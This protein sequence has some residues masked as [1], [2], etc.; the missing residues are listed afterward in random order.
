MH[1]LLFVDLDDTLFHSHNKRQPDTHDVALAYLQDGSAISYANQKQMTMLKFWQESHVM[2]P[3]TAR[4][5]NAFERVVIEFKHGAVINYGGIVLQADG[6][7]DEAW[8]QQ[9]QAHARHS[10]PILQVLLDY[11]NSLIQTTEYSSLH[12]RIISDVG[13]A[14]Y[15][16]LKSKTGDLVQVAQ[17]T[18]MV[19]QFL[20][21]EGWTEYQV[22]H[23][24]NNLAIMPPWLNKRHGVRYL[25]AQWQQRGEVVSFGMGD[26]VID[27]GFMNECDY[28]MVP[29]PSQIVSQRMDV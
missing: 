1:K 20:A 8:S 16:L 23:N 13:I 22:H 21:Q 6:S 11:L 2:I 26:S 3:V 15:V 18:H 25:L 5:R 9:S 12:A 17:V 24:G 19:K 29:N 14:F 27:L 7:L 10:E 28:L 4:N